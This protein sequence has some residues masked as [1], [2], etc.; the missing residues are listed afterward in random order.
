MT[1]AVLAGGVSVYSTVLATIEILVNSRTYRR[2]SSQKLRIT[3]RTAASMTG[4][5]AP[6]TSDET[7]LS[8]LEMF[9]IGSSKEVGAR[10]DPH[11]WIKR[12]V[13]D[14]QVLREG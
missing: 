5:V 11:S 13:L 3:E 14:R 10:V 2:V 12:D 6:G 8:Q 9:P 1:I 4:L 7:S